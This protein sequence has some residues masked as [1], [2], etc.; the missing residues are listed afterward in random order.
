MKYRIAKPFC[1]LAAAVA[2]V[3]LPVQAQAQAQ[4]QQ[5]QQEVPEIPQDELETFAQAYLAIAEVRQDYEAQL[6]QANDPEVANQLQQEA[7]QEMT[8]VLQDHGMEV[9]QYT[10]IT[11][12]LNVDEEQRAEFE[13]ILQELEGGGL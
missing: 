13:T 3:G 4:P 11:Q 1:A 6:Q 9:Q 2:L 5:P 8:A 7:N 10:R 12:V